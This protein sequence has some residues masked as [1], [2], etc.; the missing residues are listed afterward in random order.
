MRVNGKT[1]RLT[2]KV[3]I[4]KKMAL[5]MLGSGSK[6]FNTVSV[7]KNGPTALPTKANTIKAANTALENS[8]GATATSIKA[9]SSRT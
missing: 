2:A 4:L 3:F 7:S 9:N 5:H 8:S 1:T 6:I